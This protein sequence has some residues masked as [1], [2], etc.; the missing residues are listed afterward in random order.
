M[1]FHIR[2]TLRIAM[3]DQPGGAGKA[4]RFG[5]GTLFGALIGGFAFLPFWEAWYWWVLLLGIPALL[6][7]YFA[8]QWGDDFWT[9]IVEHLWWFGG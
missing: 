6:C 7:G 5:C 9:W 8:M 4:L 1:L 2:L 3:D